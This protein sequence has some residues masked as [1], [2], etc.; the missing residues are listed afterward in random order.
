[1]FIVLPVDCITLYCCHQ[2]L[3]K[4]QCE[5]SE[6]EQ[7]LQINIAQFIILTQIEVLYKV[8]CKVVFINLKHGATTNVHPMYW[9]T[10]YSSY[11]IYR[12]LARPPWSREGHLFPSLP[13]CAGPHAE[14]VYRFGSPESLGDE[15]CR[16]AECF[17][18]RY[19][20]LSTVTRCGPYERAS[21]LP[22]APSGTNMCIYLVPGTVLCSAR[23]YFVCAVNLL[24]PPV[25]LGPR[26]RARKRRRAA[27][28]AHVM[29]HPTSVKQCQ[30]A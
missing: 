30:N 28:C 2:R 12:N 5:I 8:T 23:Y 24:Y 4:L 29:R 18:P 3:I 21:S 16:G 1:M 14:D 13:I 11:V 17:R 6:R 7:A 15:T 10:Y 22:G 20:V 9:L 27:L 19:D 25:A 26:Y